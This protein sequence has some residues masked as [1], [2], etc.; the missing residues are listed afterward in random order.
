MID[1]KTKEAEFFAQHKETFKRLKL[2]D[3]FFTIKT[4]FYKK[5]KEGR[6]VQFFE[7]E[8]EKGTDIFVEF[9]DYV[10]TN[11]GKDMEPM[12]VTRQLFKYRTNPFYKEEYDT[13]INVNKK[14]E[15][16]KT[17]LIPVSELLAVLKD[18]SMIT[19]SDFEADNYT[20]PQEQMTVISSFPDFE[21]EI[22][23]DEADQPMHDMTIKDFC[24]IMWKEPISEKEWLN[25][26]IKK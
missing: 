23:S 18:G 14:G 24:A 19:Y 7:W 8:L 15:E 25:N 17:Y 20:E 6:Q 26:L 5:G 22:K 21:E 9:Y 10:D 13:K 11:R 4:A 16:Y 12:Y 1:R 3:P 2:H